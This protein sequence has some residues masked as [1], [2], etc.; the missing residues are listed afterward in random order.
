[1]C[2]IIYS[3]E[4]TKINVQHVYTA[5]EANT[6]GIGIS[7]L[8]SK[9]KK[10]KVIKSIEP[11]KLLEQPKTLDILEDEQSSVVVHLRYATHGSVNIK[12]VHPFKTAFGGY[13][14][15]NGIIT[16]PNV[17][18]LS[19]EKDITDS[20]AFVELHLNKK[21][22]KQLVENLIGSSKIL[23][24]N[25]DGSATIYNE[26]FGVWVDGCWYS[27]TGY[28]SYEH[29]YPYE[30]STDTRFYDLIDEIYDIL[31]NSLH[32]EKIVNLLIDEYYNSNSNRL[33]F[34]Y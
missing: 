8:C 33:G 22:K 6:H 28:M 34:V 25:K 13:A 24:H 17:L 18:K 3:P 29:L 15:H 1:M 27:N 7:Y 10:L 14:H 30:K 16:T 32:T 2:I 21:H 4:S 11:Y 20:Q 31:P 23:L 26:D 19:Q 5:L 12:N 9:T